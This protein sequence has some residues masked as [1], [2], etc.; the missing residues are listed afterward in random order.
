MHPEL[1]EALR[2]AKSEVAAADAGLSFRTRKALLLQ[3]GPLL[4]DSNGR[5]SIVSPGLIRRA[6]L[7]ISIVE[8]VLPLWEQHYPSK[9]PH[10]LLEEARVYLEGR[11][12]RQEPDLVGRRVS[13]WTGYVE[14]SRQT[15]GLP[16]R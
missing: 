16:G 12:S 2:V 4:T 15:G 13:G 10:R 1:L 3:M 9:H 7:C 14:H 11:S 5:H 8:R 6:H